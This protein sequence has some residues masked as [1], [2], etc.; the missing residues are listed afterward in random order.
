[1]KNSAKKLGLATRAIHHGYDPMRYEGALN[2]PVFLTSTYE[3]PDAETGAARFAGT[4]NGYIYS[5]MGNPTVAVLEAK[6][7][8]LESAEAAVAMSSAA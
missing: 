6:L 3:F 5:R 1:M 7:A 2:P 4:D 8:N